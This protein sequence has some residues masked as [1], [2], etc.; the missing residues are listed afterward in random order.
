MVF[1]RKPQGVVQAEK[2]G[3]LFDEQKH[4][5]AANIT[6]L[7]AID[8]NTWQIQAFYRERA[9]AENVFDELKNQWRFSGFCSRQRRVS[10][11]AARLLLLVYNLWNLFVRLLEA[12]RHVEAAGGRRWS[13]TIAAWLVQRGRQRTLQVSVQCAWWQQLHDGNTRGGVWRATTAQQ[14]KTPP[15]APAPVAP[16]L[17]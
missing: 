14:L 11:L 15:P 10:A 5:L 1:A 13:L 2:S 6:N 16:V 9:N 7:D 3:R 17:A 12:Q 4:E 8:Y